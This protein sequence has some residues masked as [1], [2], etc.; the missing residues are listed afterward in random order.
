MAHSYC[1]I[2]IHLVFSTKN[3]CSL[4]TDDIREEL[5]AYMIGI[6]RHLNSPSIRINST[7]DHAHILFLL[8]K[9]HAVDFVIEELK[10]SSSKWIKAKGTE[11]TDFYWQ[12]GYA[13]FSVGQK[14]VDNVVKYIENQKEHHQTISFA[15]E[16]RELFRMA[17]VEFDEKHFFD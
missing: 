17:G 13:A 15:D 11:F 1:R 8:S 7:S 16:V 12:F 6:L 4:I 2:V 10:K 9:K 3:R 5:H 14:G